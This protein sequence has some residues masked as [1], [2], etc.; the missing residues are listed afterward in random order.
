ME[1]HGCTKVP[2]D[3]DLD[4][5]PTKDT[6]T[7]PIRYFGQQS[8]KIQGIWVDGQKKPIREVPLEI[9]KQVPQDSLDK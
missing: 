7:S 9:F 1:T 3:T 2:Y 8:H 6:K 5:S 4:I